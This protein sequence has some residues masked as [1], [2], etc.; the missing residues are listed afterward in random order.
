MAAAN[1]LE[2]EG[3]AAGGPEGR[4]PGTSHAA[5]RRGARGVTGE[6]RWRSRPCERPA[7]A[8]DGCDSEASVRRIVTVSACVALL[9][10][11]AELALRNPTRLITARVHLPELVGFLAGLGTTLA[12]LP[13]LLAMLRRRS[14]RGM[15]PRM[16]A[17][18]GLFQLLWLY[19]G[20]LIESRPVVV[21]NT[22]G[23]AIN[24][25]NVSAY[26]YF[27]RRERTGS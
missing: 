16:P 6:T 12:A 13:D 24:T 17:I 3:L 15:N 2:V 18:T 7:E 9:C 25:L 11:C 22:F 14:S 4:L 21:W 19:Y 23:A 20:L 27:S 26:L 8:W 1:G 10:G 5:W